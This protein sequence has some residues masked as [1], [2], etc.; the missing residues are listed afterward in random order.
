MNRMH[1]F[2]VL[3]PYLFLLYVLGLFG[4][5]TFVEGQGGIEGDILFISPRAGLESVWSLPLA[6][7]AP[8]H[9]FSVEN[10]HVLSVNLSHSRQEIAIVT[11]EATGDHHTG[12][13]LI[14]N[15]DG[16][17]LSEIFVAGSAPHPPVVW[18][19][20]DRF[21]VYPIL[22]SGLQRIERDGTHQ[23]PL[24]PVETSHLWDDD[25]DI[26]P[27]GDIVYS[28]SELHEIR[29]TSLAG[30][31]G[32]LIKEVTG[33]TAPQ[34]SPDGDRI[35]YNEID[36]GL[37]TMDRDGSNETL[38]LEEQE[39]ETLLSGDWSPLGVLYVRVMDLTDERELWIMNADGTGNRRLTSIPFLPKRPQWLTQELLF[40]V[41]NW[42]LME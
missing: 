24:T 34:W 35:L 8:Q 3:R 23:Q 41:E 9:V 38:L 39:G 36:V 5:T 33:P 26:T 6:G 1:R 30:E 15:L 17:N 42:I 7:G 37:K 4:G 21:L 32:V 14:G 19:P 25:P 12:K 16:S 29:I 28:N 20:D 22:E 13:I 18:S 10:R 40:S 31:A 2:S 27:E 11:Q